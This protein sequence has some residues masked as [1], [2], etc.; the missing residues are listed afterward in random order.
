MKAPVPFRFLV[1]DFQDAP[2]WMGRLFTPL[3]R[4]GEQTIACLDGGISLSENLSTRSFSTNI[5]TSATYT[6]GTFDPV[7][8]SWPFNELPHLMMVT[9][10]FKADNTLFLG[11]V[12]IPQ[13]YYSSGSINIIYIPGLANSIKYVIKFIAI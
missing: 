3:N 7:T 13:W 5:T 11:S 12:G 10:I 8:F 6:S 1:E 2:L 9:Q 4:F